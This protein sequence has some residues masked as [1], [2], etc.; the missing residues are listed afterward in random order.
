LL[1]IEF[2]P[3][4]IGTI[5]NVYVG[6]TSETLDVLKYYNGRLNDERY[7]CY[8]TNLHVNHNYFIQGCGNAYSIGSESS[9]T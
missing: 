5:K 7:N 8:D 4:L 1:T 2:G 6:E 9:E 3:G